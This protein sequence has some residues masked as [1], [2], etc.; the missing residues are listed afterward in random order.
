[1]I[2]TKSDDDMVRTMHGNMKIYEN[3]TNF[4]NILLDHNNS[5]HISAT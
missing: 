1:M 2:L 5:Y 4:L 3:L